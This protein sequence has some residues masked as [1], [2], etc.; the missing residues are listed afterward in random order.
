MVTKAEQTVSPEDAVIA[1]PKREFNPIIEA[2][3]YSW[4]VINGKWVDLDQGGPTYILVGHNFK[5]R[6]TY[7]DGLINEK[8]PEQW[9][10]LDLQYCHPTFCTRVIPLL[11]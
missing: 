11:I 6:R 8:I 3:R 2:A 10:L 9:N 4:Q 7:F 1:I 5:G